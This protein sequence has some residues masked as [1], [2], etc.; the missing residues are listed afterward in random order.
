MKP[1]KPAT[2][3]APDGL[4]TPPVQEAD[5]P[6]AGRYEV[7]QFWG[8]ALDTKQPPTPPE[9]SAVASL[10]ALRLSLPLPPMPKTVSEAR[11]K[12]GSSEA[13]KPTPPKAQDPAPAPAPEDTNKIFSVKEL[14]GPRKRKVAP[15]DTGDQPPSEEVHDPNADTISIEPTEKLS[16]SQRRKLKKSKSASQTPTGENSEDS[17]PFNYDNA[18]S[19]LHAKPSQPAGSAPKQPFNPYAKAMEAPSGARK[20]KK[21]SSGKQFTFR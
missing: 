1:S 14:G 19:V 13:S 18:D 10:E 6:T 12:L 9:Y 20:G 5:F 8:T 17:T 16:K 11:D 21:P 2:A 4:L 7:S 15:T 3:D